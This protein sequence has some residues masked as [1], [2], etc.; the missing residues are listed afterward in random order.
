M[1]LIMPL[2][3]DVQVQVR[4][5]YTRSWSLIIV[6]KLSWAFIPD[7]RVVNLGPEHPN[8]K[9]VTETCKRLRAAALRNRDIIWQSAIE[10]NSI[11]LHDSFVMVL[12]ESINLHY[13]SYDTH[14]C[15]VSN[16]KM[17]AASH[18]CRRVGTTA[19]SCSAHA[20]DCEKSSE[21]LHQND[22]GWSFTTWWVAISETWFCSHIGKSPF[23]HS[24]FNPELILS[25]AKY[26]L[27]GFSL[28]WM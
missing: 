5:W 4:D 18:T 9:V 17:T 23:C 2:S 12:L 21:S 10:I 25:I 7:F 16:F 14:W 1:R 8:I 6:P 15:V 20:G 13:T 27:L 3:H 24:L 22:R 26:D 28:L 19:A 11:Q